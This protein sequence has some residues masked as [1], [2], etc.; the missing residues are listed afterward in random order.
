VFIT[1]LIAGMLAAGAYYQDDKAGEIEIGQGK[2][3][4]SKQYFFEIPRILFLLNLLTSRSWGL[5]FIS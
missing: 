2:I 1:A 5:C 3:D 4:M